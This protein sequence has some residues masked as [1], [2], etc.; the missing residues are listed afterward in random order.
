MLSPAAFQP[1]P[2]VSDLEMAGGVG[3]SDAGLLDEPSTE[4]KVCAALLGAGA[5]GGVVER[6]VIGCCRHP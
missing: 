1:K 2:E 3:L 6:E 4:R 5:G